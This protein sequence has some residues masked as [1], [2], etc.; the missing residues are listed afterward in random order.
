MIAGVEQKVHFQCFDLPHADD[1][2]VIAFPAEIPGVHLRATDSLRRASLYPTWITVQIHL[3]IPDLRLLNPMK[4]ARRAAQRRA[5][6]K[7]EIE[8][9]RETPPIEAR[10]DASTEDRRA[11]DSGNCWYFRYFFSSNEI[12]SV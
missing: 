4:K 3:G 8:P 9:R 11:R 2:F 6:P 10:S 5:Q 12:R 7:Q 1:C